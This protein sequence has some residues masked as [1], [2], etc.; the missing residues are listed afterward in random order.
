MIRNKALENSD[1]STLIMLLEL[2]AQGLD[3]LSERVNDIITKSDKVNKTEMAP[4]E[5][6]L[7]ERAIVLALAYK[8][9]DLLKKLKDK[10][11]PQE[12]LEVISGQK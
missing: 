10:T 3:S 2:S 7:E 12:R 8:H 11:T 1:L 9:G 6:P 5:I 4:L